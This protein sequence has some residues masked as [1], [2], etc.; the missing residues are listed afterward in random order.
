MQ[1]TDFT[2][3]FYSHMEMASGANT[4]SSSRG[5]FFICRWG[6]GGGGGLG[7]LELNID[8]IS[9][10]IAKF[11]TQSL[12]TSFISGPNISHVGAYVFRRPKLSCAIVS[13]QAIDFTLPVVSLVLLLLSPLY[14]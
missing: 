14:A 10:L 13:G 12:G 3:L 8:F 11:T 9:V 1:N 5:H 2:S 4:E 6:G 7:I